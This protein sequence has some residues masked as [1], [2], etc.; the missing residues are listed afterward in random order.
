MLYDFIT[1][2][3]VIVPQT[4]D[5]LA[6]VQAEWQAIFGADLVVDGNTPQGLLINAET[7][8]RANVLQTIATIA[9]QLNPNLA[10]GIYFDAIWALTGGQRTAQSYSMVSVNVTGVPTTLIPTSAAASYNGYTFN[11]VASIT[12]DSTGN[13]NGIFICQ[14][15]GA[16]AVPAN[17]LTTIE[18]GVLG[19]ETITNPTAGTLGASTQS[20]QSAHIQRNQ[21]L[22]LQGIAWAEA[23]QSALLSPFANTGVTSLY[24]IDNPLDT[25]VTIDT[26]TLLPHSIYVCVAG[27]S[28]STFEQTV[29]TILL[30][31][32]SCGANWNGSTTVNIT[33]PVSSISY[34]VSFDIATQIPILTKVYVN[35]SNAVVNITAA[36]TQAILDYAAGLLPGRPGFVVNA[37]VSCFELA[38]A[39]NSEVPQIFITNVETTLASLI[40]YSNAE[41]PIAINQ[42][43]TINASGIV[44][45]IN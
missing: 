33:D 27:G 4:G 15:P 18:S 26:I 42:I 8:A 41:I 10:G 43:A 32:K 23:I 21:T 11:P 40:D 29:A 5:L 45:V 36:V 16:I 34:P 35:A 1:T 31:K 17:G 9:N 20:D 6:Q 13:G 2:T 14:T 44:V 19:W 25:S 3:G 12:L 30:D 39:I 28:G 7:L 22:A 37:S 38:G 24:A